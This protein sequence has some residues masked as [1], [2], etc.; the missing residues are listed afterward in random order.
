VGKDGRAMSWRDRVVADKAVLGGKPVVRGT[1]LAVDF[2]LDLLAA[3]WSETQ[4]L[5]EYPQLAREDV[6]ACLA[7]R[8]S[9]SARSG[10]TRCRPPDACACSPTRT[11]RGRSP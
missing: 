11:C 4:V 3:G 6:L 5:A 10:S 8:P 7:S 2:V 9:L 1:R